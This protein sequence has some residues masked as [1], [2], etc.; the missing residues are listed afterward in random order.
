M[1]LVG[2]PSSRRGGHPEVSGAPLPEIK[3]PPACPSC[4][5]IQDSHLLRRQ[6]YTCRC[7]YHFRIN[8][9]S[10]V[11][12]LPDAGSW[13]E[14][15]TELQGRDVLGWQTPRDYH[16]QLDRLQAHTES[17]RS[18]TCQLNGHPIWLCVFDFE[19]MGGTLGLVAG[20]RLTRAIEQSSESGVP[21]VVVFASGGARMQEGTLALMQMAKINA[22]LSRLHARST[23]YFSVLSDPTFGG[24]AA[25]L[26]LLAD[27]NLAEP[28]ASIG[29]TGARVIQQ[30]TYATLPPGFQSAGYQMNHGQVDLIVPRTELRQTLSRLLYLYG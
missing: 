24:T 23:P 9:D 16:E 27:V 3:H 21:I 14:R 22:A 12:L 19:F 15:F 2:H 5:L 30:A 25:S 20:E 13:R 18:G 26:A 17:V 6:V 8:A 10:W 1:I 7:G 29:F 4:G 28:G 11:A